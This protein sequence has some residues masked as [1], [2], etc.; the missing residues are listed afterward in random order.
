MRSGVLISISSRQRSAIS[1]RK[2]PER[3]DLEPA[4][5]SYYIHLHSSNF[6][7][8]KEKSKQANKQTSIYKQNTKIATKSSN[9]TQNSDIKEL[10]AQA[11][12]TMA[13]IPQ[14]SPATAHYFTSEY[15]QVLIRYSLTYPG[16]VEG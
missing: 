1:G 7:S 4:V 16:G 15:Y 9:C 2:L 14:C 3:T 5:C 10:Y 11:S 6:D 8:K 13:F 12:R